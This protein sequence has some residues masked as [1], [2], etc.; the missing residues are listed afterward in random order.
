MQAAKK[1]PE[2]V[3]E[4]AEKAIEA[5]QPDKP[6]EVPAPDPL[7][8][9]TDAAAP[10]PSPQTPVK[11]AAQVEIN[12]LYLPK[13]QRKDHGARSLMQGLRLHST[14]AAD[15]CEARKTM[16]ASRQIQIFSFAM[17]Q[18]VSHPLANEWCWL[19][20]G[21]AGSGTAS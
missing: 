10:S 21:T 13:D 2:P 8:P 9:K 1:V 6:A 20:G 4:V 14:M 17:V 5:P 12:L 16:L 3:K 19:A 18:T 11:A 7:K 15:L